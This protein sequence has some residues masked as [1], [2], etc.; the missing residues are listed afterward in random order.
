MV[1]STQEFFLFTQELI[2][3][4]QEILP[5]LP[6]KLRTPYSRNM[7]VPN[8]GQLV[9][10]MKSAWNYMKF[11]VLY[12][13][14]ENKKTKYIYFLRCS[15]HRCGSGGSMRACHAAGPGSISGRDKF[16]GWGFFGIFPHL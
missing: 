14:S 15:V 11:H 3:F 13:F 6:K 5:L 16:P 1:F 7:R 10:V 4:T 12:Y 2:H 8:N 9:T